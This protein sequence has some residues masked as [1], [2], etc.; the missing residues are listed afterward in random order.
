[1]FSEF[2]QNYTPIANTF[3]SAIFAAIPIIVLLVMLGILRTAAH[4]AAAAAL[5]SAILVALIV[6][7]MPFGLDISATAYGAAYGLWPIAWIVLNA[8]F[9]HNLTIETGAFD[10]VRNSL[11]SLTTDRRL[12]ALIIAFS[13]GALL[14]GIAGFGAPVAITAAIMA[15]LG[16]RSIYAA[17]IAL[18][19]NTAPVAFGSIGIP[20]VALGGLV[21][22]LIG[23]PETNVT[24]A[25]AAMVGRQLPLFAVII[26]GFLVFVMAG[27]RGMMQ[28]FP[29]VATAGLSFAITQF[30]VSNFI[31]PQL[32]DILG[33]LV[34]LA[35][36]VILL[37]VWQPS[38][39]WRFE[40]ED[41]EAGASAGG[42]VQE[43]RDS[44]A[45]SRE[46]EMSEAGAAT[47]MSGLRAWSPYIILVVVIVL[48]RLGDLVPG[49]PE[50]LQPGYWLD[51]ATI[52]FSWP[53]LDGLVQRVAPIVPKQTPYPAEYTFNILS[54]AGTIV[55]FAAIIAG[56]VIGASVPTM[57]RV[58]GQ[59]I[60]QMK[61]ALLTIAMILAIAFVMNYSGMTSTLGLA[62]AATGF[63]FPFFSA[64]IGWLGVFLSGSDTASNS[65][66]G[67]MQVVTA[68]QLGIN[69]VI[70]GATNSS[71]G[72]MGKMISPQNLTVGASAIGQVGK[73]ADIFRM[74]FKW[75]VILAASVGILSMIQVHLI[76]WIAP[77]VGG[78]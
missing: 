72:V 75:S 64:F 15:S 50:N 56:F 37:R 51:K 74:T 63:F 4:W 34:S 65:L 42:S 40:G 30:L 44:V 17:S 16:F 76:P 61:M 73:E 69:P 5:L 57:I 12:Q 6:Y 18:L 45:E 67:P 70:A 20:V 35:A 36:L 62:F 9:I 47:S 22:P 39:V 60:N 14:E 26:P 55:L 27:W 7:G 54:A 41:E 21:A 53:G 1:M 11:S 2:V 49:L 59:T 33:S 3:V 38:S 52:V 43:P 28:V 24:N 48:S 32:V 19:A 23:A 66:F 78:G 46:D 71:G 13:F 25:L 29:A 58:Y 68:Q 10:V 8:I 31:G 77:V